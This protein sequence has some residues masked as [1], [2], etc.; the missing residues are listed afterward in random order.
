MSSKNV[1]LHMRKQTIPFPSFLPG[2]VHGKTYKYMR[3]RDEEHVEKGDSCSRH[4]ENKFLSEKASSCVVWRCE[5]KIL[6]LCVQVF[7]CC[8]TKHFN[9]SFTDREIFRLEVFWKYFQRQN[10]SAQ[11][12]TTCGYPEKDSKICQIFCV[13]CINLCDS[14]W[15]I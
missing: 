8:V 5:V 2:V 11:S 7:L 10:D 15:S 4:L 12:Q 9:N 14:V 3:L 6:W 13:L 1:E